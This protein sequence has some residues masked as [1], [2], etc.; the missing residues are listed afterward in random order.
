MSILRLNATIQAGIGKGSNNPTWEY[1]AVTRWSTIEG[2]VG[3]MCACMPS[4]RILLVRIFPKVLGTSRRHYYAY[5]S[6][7]YGSNKP[8]NGGTNA[9]R[10]RS[11]APLGTTSHV[12]KT[13][14]SRVDPLGITCNRTYEVEY[15]QTDETQLVPMKDLD[16]DLHSGRS[17]GS[18]A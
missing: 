17:Q 15:G 9:S 13:P 6:N 5:D 2:N 16:M 11:R 14:R 10:S 1:L 18:Q 8:T 3:I 12:D 4:L 7:K